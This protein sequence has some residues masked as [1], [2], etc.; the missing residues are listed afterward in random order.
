MKEKIIKGNSARLFLI[1]RKILPYQPRAFSGG[2]KFKLSYLFLTN[3]VLSP[4]VVRLLNI[5]KPRKKS[6]Q[7]G[8]E[9]P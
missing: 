3:I 4:V 5:K 9:Q 7:D 2:L 6:A 8:K 1:L